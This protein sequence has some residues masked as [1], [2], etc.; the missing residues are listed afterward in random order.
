MTRMKFLK[1]SIAVNIISGLI[2]GILW[3]T[4]I[5]SLFIFWTCI[6]LFVA[7]YISLFTLIYSL[8]DHK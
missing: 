1:I 4:E 6:V 3:L 5:N 7:S 8:L 2:F